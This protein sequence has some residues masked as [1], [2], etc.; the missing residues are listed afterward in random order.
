MRVIF[1]DID[2][3]LNSA[4]YYRKYGPKPAPH[5]LDPEAINYVN[6]IAKR[7]RA[8]IVVSSTWRKWYTLPVLREHLRIAGLTAPIV[9]K[10]P[11]IERELMK[12]LYVSAQRGKEIQRW[13]DTTRRK[14]ESFVI[15]DDDNDM[16]GLEKYHV[17]TDSDCGLTIADVERAFE[18]LTGQ[19]GHRR[20][21]AFQRV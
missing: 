5:A 7:A 8:S 6:A 19:K 18:I 3:V 20:D 10:T 16:T 14:V 13:L 1:L 17:R 4:E 12:G 15:L 11:V 9:G 2:G 21:I